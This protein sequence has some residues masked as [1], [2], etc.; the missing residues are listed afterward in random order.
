MD[1]EN[2]LT[3]E[4]LKYRENSDIFSDHVASTQKTAEEEPEDT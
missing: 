2:Y 4:H 1:E 3:P